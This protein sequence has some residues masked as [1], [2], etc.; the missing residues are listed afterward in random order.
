MNF[1]LIIV[2]LKVILLQLLRPT[3]LPKT[4]AFYVYEVLKIVIVYKHKNFM[5][6]TL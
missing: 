1:A 2:N 6:V 5:P 4:Q 3:E